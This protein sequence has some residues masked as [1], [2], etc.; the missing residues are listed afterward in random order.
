MKHFSISPFDSGLPGATVRRLSLLTSDGPYA[1]VRRILC[2]DET[3]LILE[4]QL[5]H[6]YVLLIFQFL[7]NFTSTIFSSP[8][9]C[10]RKSGRF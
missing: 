5:D 7:G 6:F 10:M 8:C 3:A 2:C 9:S 1:A 4:M